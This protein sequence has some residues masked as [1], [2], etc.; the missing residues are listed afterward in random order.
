MKSCTE[1]K[2][3][4]IINGI[5]IRSN[6]IKCL[7]FKKYPGSAIAGVALVVVTA[8]SFRTKSKREVDG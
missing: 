1:K 6:S 4:E 8:V 7:R 2:P 5:A 3:V